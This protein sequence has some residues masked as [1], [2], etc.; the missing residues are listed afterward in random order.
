MPEYSEKR[1]CRFF[2]QGVNSCLS[3]LWQEFRLPINIQALKERLPD[4]SE[5]A[6]AIRLDI[7]VD[8]T[9]TLRWHQRYEEHGLDGL[10]DVRIGRNR[11]VPKEICTTICTLRRADPNIAVEAIISNLEEY[12]DFKIVAQR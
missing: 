6:A 8:R 3:K 2:S 4:E 11:P 7:K 12:Y 10:I 1:F 9:T 5:R